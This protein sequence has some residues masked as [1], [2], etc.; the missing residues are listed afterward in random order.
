MANE[1]PPKIHCDAFLAANADRGVHKPPHD[2]DR[3]PAVAPSVRALPDDDATARR[4]TV[5]LA[6]SR[7]SFDVWAALARL[8]I[9]LSDYRRL[10]PR[11]SFEQLTGEASV[12]A[13]NEYRH[14]VSDS[15]SLRRIEAVCGGLAG[16]DRSGALNGARTMD[17]RVTRAGPW[18]GET[19]E[20]VV[21]ALEN[22]AMAGVASLWVLVHGED[23]DGPI[24]LRLDVFEIARW[25]W[26][27]DCLAARETSGDDT[28]AGIVDWPYLFERLA[29]YIDAAPASWATDESFSI[30]ASLSTLA[31]DSRVAD[32]LA[33]HPSLSRLFCR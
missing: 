25:A 29:E 31:S 21:E 3:P 30:T 18:G 2:F 33:V 16:A 4:L 14:T 8:D 15:A 11:F 20:L 32:A 27:P 22:H 17:I 24:R 5:S 12:A 28:S 19:G 6:T 1:T 9:L 7:P 23:M 13:G 26:A 10:A